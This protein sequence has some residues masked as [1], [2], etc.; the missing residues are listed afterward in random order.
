MRIHAGFRWLRSG[1]RMSRPR[2]I[3]AAA[4]LSLGLAVAMAPSAEAATWPNHGKW[5]CDVFW[6]NWSA[7]SSHVLTVEP[8]LGGPYARAAMQRYVSGQPRW[9]YG[10]WVKNINSLSHNTSPLPYVG[11]GTWIGDYFQDD[12]GGSYSYHLLYNGG[13]TNH[14]CS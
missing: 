3:G 6:A 14:L 7:S 10:P 5:D 1:A 9:Y 12:G 4:A 13:S 11:D 2:C 8:H